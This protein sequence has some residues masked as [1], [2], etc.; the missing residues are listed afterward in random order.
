MTLL[1]SAIL[2]IVEGITEFLPISSTGHL[3]LTGTLLGL[4]PTEFLKSF[5][6]A[7]QLGAI[8][9]V[10]VLYWR[11][12]LDF[13]VLKKIAAAFIPTAII[14]LL[15][16]GFA[17]TYL[18]G[19]VEVVLWAL[20][21]G[22]VALILFELIHKEKEDGVDSVSAITYPQAIVVGV[23]QAF[24]IVPGVSR[25]AATIIGGLVMGIRRIAIVEFS[26]LLAVPVMVAATALDLSK[27]AHTFSSAD[28]GNLSVGFVVSF[29]VALL[30]IRFLLQ[31]VRKHTFISF[32]VYR[33]VLALAFFL[34]VL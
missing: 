5:E 12:F 28:F 11:S 20:G 7:I 15:L 9:A 34:F 4:P 27:S 29:V 23:F 18:L 13:S 32:G 31:Y 19:N 8:L 25:S 14:G 3:I 24:A 17:K 6:I 16:H 33:I 22:G 26:F 30:A 21:I 2:G 10:V 1:D